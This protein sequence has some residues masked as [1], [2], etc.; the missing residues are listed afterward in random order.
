[1]KSHILKEGEGYGVY[2]SLIA[3]NT[4]QGINKKLFVVTTIK[5]YPEYNESVH[6]EVCNHDR[7]QI[8]HSLSTAKE[9]YNLI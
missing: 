9:F 1:M 7:V 3:G 8:C 2:H 5:S 4:D 6:Y